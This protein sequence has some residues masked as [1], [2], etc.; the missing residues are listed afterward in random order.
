MKLFNS[1]A[2]LALM[3][4]TISSISYAAKPAPTV[5]PVQ[6][7]APKTEAEKFE[8]MQSMINPSKMHK[9]VVRGVMV[10]GLLLPRLLSDAA[11]GTIV[12]IIATF[13]FT[14]DVIESMTAILLT[15]ILTVIADSALAPKLQKHLLQG[16]APEGNVLPIV[17][18]CLGT[19]VYA[20]YH[21]YFLSTT[22]CFNKTVEAFK[23]APQNFPQEAR[24]ILHQATQDILPRA[25]P[26]KE[27]ENKKRV[28][29]IV[30]KTMV[31]L[32]ALKAPKNSS[33]KNEMNK[34]EIAQ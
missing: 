16:Q 11:V 6:K 28:G 26:Q 4:C 5:M 18:G 33:E 8:Y 13:V 29:A 15:C 12:G 10:P 24:K 20:L 25:C 31:E 21:K 1:I 9:Q 22:C 32:R 19:A 14:P 30:L 2:L 7:S 3:V 34:T 23:N 17:D 27:V